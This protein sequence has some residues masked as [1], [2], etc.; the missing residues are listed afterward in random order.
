MSDE[1]PSQGTPLVTGTGDGYWLLVIERLTR[2]ETNLKNMA[3]GRDDHE[4]RLRKLEERKFPLP[5]VAVLISLAALVTTWVMY[6]T[7]K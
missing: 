7:Q 2:I 6:V 3:Q 5:T 1:T 4:Q